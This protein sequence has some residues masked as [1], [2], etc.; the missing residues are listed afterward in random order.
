MTADNPPEEHRDLAAAAQAYVDGQYR[1]YLECRGQP[2]PAWAWVNELAHGGRADLEEL[3][4]LRRFFAGP[5]RL[6]GSLAAG[7]AALDDARLGRVQRT[8]LEPL[9]AALRV[10]PAAPPA[11][12]LEL[13]QVIL[14]GLRNSVP[15]RAE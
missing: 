5:K 15:P 2:V 13:A 6:I 4:A 10:A 8:R 12:E 1:S 14:A 11:S 3:A 7:L 9:E